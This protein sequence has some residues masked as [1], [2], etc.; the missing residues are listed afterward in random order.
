MIVR[1]LKLSG[2]HRLTLLYKLVVVA[3]SF[4]EVLYLQQLIHILLWLLLLLVKLMP[5]GVGQGSSLRMLANVT[6]VMISALS[7]SPVGKRSVARDARRA[8]HH[9]RP[10]GGGDPGR[11]GLPSRVVLHRLRSFLSLVLTFHHLD[12]LQIDG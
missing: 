6:S 4:F 7:T 12:T 11:L 2:S 1:R 9:Q 10:F 8:R 3:V 5:L